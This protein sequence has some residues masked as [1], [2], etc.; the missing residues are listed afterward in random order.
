[1]PVDAVAQTSMV[2]A[3]DPDSSFEQLKTDRAL[4]ANSSSFSTSSL[5]TSN[6]GIIRMTSVSEI[7]EGQLLL[8][9]ADATIASEEGEICMGNM[10]TGYFADLSATSEDN[11]SVPPRLSRLR[12]KSFEAAASSDL[13]TRLS[14]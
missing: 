14:S 2:S 7:S 10:T 13:A 3:V 4:E 11:S 9:P 12:R 5:D 1:M 8:G 6:P